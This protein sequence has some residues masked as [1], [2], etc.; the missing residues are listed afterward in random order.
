MAVAPV[1][2]ELM[3]RAIPILFAQ[4]AAV[5]NQPFENFETAT[6]SSPM[7]L[8][9]SKDAKCVVRC[10]Y[11]IE[12]TKTYLMS[13]GHLE[14]HDKYQKSSSFPQGLCWSSQQGSV[15]CT[16]MCY[17]SLNSTVWFS[18]KQTICKRLCT[19]LLF[20]WH[21]MDVLIVAILVTS[22][23]ILLLVDTQGFSH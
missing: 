2:Y 14:G 4:Y 6:A 7:R 9:C 10:L 12:L 1:H 13:Y 16:L 20:F 11:L 18:F 22:N 21:S 17:F 19:N 15:Q 3:S 23:Y 5:T 8:C